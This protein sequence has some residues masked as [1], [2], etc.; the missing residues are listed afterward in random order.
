MLQTHFSTF[1]CNCGVSVHLITFAG[2]M[3]LKLFL[4]ISFIV[5]HHE[6]E[7]TNKQ[8]SSHD[9]RNNQLSV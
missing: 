8:S 3:A 2:E 9:D 6:N 1:K 4:R 5:D 7:M